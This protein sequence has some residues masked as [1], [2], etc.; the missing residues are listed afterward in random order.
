MSD[1]IFKDA[2]Y[3]PDEWQE[4]TWEEEKLVPPKVTNPQK[5]EISPNVVESLRT[6]LQSARLK[7]FSK[8][9]ETIEDLVTKLFDTLIAFQRRKDASEKEGFSGVS[10]V[11]EL[12]LKTACEID[13]ET[14][15]GIKNEIEIIN[16]ALTMGKDTID[17]EI[18]EMIRSALTNIFTT[19]TQGTLTLKGRGHGKFRKDGVGTKAMS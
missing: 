14:V 10:S 11:D 9:S 12:I 2:V 6:L 8:Q 15:A 16:Q 19:F 1:R 13:P 3:A 7:H 5:I 17:S 4:E 18:I